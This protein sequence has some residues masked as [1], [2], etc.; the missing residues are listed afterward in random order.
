[1]YKEIGKWFLDVAKYILTAVLLMNLFGN[2]DTAIVVLLAIL[3]MVALF[4]LGIY[5]LRN[6]EEDKKNQTNKRKENN[7]GLAVGFDFSNT[8]DVRG[9]DYFIFSF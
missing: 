4:I 9:W 3:A 5:F 1:M 8:C 6:D 2:S 7:Y